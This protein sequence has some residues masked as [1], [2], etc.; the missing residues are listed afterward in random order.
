MRAATRTR[1]LHLS[2]TRAA[3]RPVAE[4][5]FFGIPGGVPGG[6]PGGTSGGAFGPA[7]AARLDWVTSEVVDIVR[8]AGARARLLFQICLWL[9]SFLAPL[10]IGKLRTLGGLDVATRIRALERLERTPRGAALVLALKALLC[11]VWYE[12]PDAAREVGAYEPCDDRAP[13]LLPIGRAPAHEVH[14]S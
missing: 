4:A 14:A 12:H 9:V 2:R 13:A 5:L 10:C 7:P 11:T 3:L 1:E 8:H 6:I